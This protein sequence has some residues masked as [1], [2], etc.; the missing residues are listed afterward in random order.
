MFIHSIEE[1]RVCRDGSHKTPA[2]L[3][4]YSYKRGEEEEMAENILT[5]RHWDM[6]MGGE[7]GT[8]ERTRVSRF[9]SLWRENLCKGSVLAE[10]QGSKKKVWTLNSFPPSFPPSWFKFVCISISEKNALCHKEEN[11]SRLLW[12]SLERMQSSLCD[13]NSTRL[14]TR[15]IPLLNEHSVTAARKTTLHYLP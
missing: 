14:N 7:E 1:V 11:F 9:G 8:W 5:Q 12:Y 6:V 3:S 13:Y 15:D 4:I 10:V 2:R